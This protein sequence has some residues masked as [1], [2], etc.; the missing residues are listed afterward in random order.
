MENNLGFATDENILRQ[1]RFAYDEDLAQFDSLFEKESEPKYICPTC[2]TVYLESELR[3][4]GK[5]L[6]FCM[7]DRA[8]LQTYD[9]GALEHRYT[10]EEIKIIGSIRSSSAEDHLTA[11]RVADDV[12]C[13]VQKVA[14]FGE[15]LEREKIIGRE[16][17]E[18]LNKNIYY[19]PD[20]DE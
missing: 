9:V 20:A 18:D 14:K 5:V 19:R 7:E 11:R 6:A 13:Y 2:G 1:Q 15:K 12:G 17:M 4:K 16:K 10:E 8:T 3:I